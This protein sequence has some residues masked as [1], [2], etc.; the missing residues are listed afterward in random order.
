MT[1][2]GSLSERS[3]VVTERGRRRVNEDAVLVTTLSTG[4]ELVAVA[5][6]MG[7]YAGGEVA[8]QRTLEVLRDSLEAGRDLADAVVAANA[9]VF[10]EASVSKKHHGMGTTLV[11]L[12]RQGSHYRLVNVGD[13]RA[14]RVD[15]GGIQ[16]LTRDHSFVADAIRAGQ[17]TAEDAEKSRWRNAVT[18]AVGTH[19]ELEVDSYGP[20][21]ALE[22]HAVVLCTD[23]LY[24]A[25]SDADLRRVITGA[26][27]P[28]EAVREL[29]AAAY[30]A[31]SDDNI[32]V[33]LLRFGT[34]LA[35]GSEPPERTG[36]A[37]SGPPRAGSS[38]TGVGAPVWPDDRTNAGV[39]VEPRVSRSRGGGRW[40]LLEVVLIFLGVIVLSYAILR[41]LPF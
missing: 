16:Q 36:S 39:R 41:I 9:T 33:V 18:R 27:L 2:P 37:A 6:G 1:T 3:A 40:T 35:S 25:V 29:A 22:P 11:A 7:G 38:G 15:Q 8:S 24:R 26:A 4:A 5:D 21:Y 23:G 13:S 10:Q 30:A 19:A 34:E 31:G 17:L 14:Y 20:F 12:L 32:T 28:E